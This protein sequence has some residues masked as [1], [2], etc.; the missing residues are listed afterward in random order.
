MDKMTHKA[1]CISHGRGKLSDRHICDEICETV[2]DGE[3][4]IKLISDTSTSMSQ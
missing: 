1:R 3:D 2:P 4:W